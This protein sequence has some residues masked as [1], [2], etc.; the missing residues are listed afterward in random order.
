MVKIKIC[1]IRDSEGALACHETAVDY[2]GF[3]FVTGR[4]RS[5]TPDQASSL[6]K[7]CP[8]AK[9]VGV[10][11]NQAAEVIIETHATCPLDFIQLHGD[12]TPDYCRNISRFAPVIKAFAITDD[13]E[14]EELEEYESSVQYWLFDGAKAGKGER[15]M[16]EQL[17]SSVL[18]KPFFIAGGINQSNVSE[19]I[20]KFSPYGVDT[21]SGIEIDGKQDRN[22]ILSFCNTVRTVR[23]N[24]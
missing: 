7:L 15:F 18:N 24:S 13:F 17:D 22:S 3:N 6:H 10:F 4:R 11:M 2:V 16:W 9:A 23:G 1:G 5:V 20:S 19:A 14:L 12:E 21:A 8:Q